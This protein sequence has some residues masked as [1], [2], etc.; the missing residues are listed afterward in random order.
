MG[1][2]GLIQREIV[3]PCGA[4]LSGGIKPSVEDPEGRVREPVSTSAVLT[5][6]GKY[7]PGDWR[8]HL[9]WKDTAACVALVGSLCER[10]TT[11]HEFLPYQPCIAVPRTTMAMTGNAE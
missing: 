3:P 8:A 7:L 1:C 2:T 10:P 6:C 11:L 4:L 9:T 5:A